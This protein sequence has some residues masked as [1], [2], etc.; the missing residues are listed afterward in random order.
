MDT[1]I[2]DR[3]GN[4][5]LE[6][7]GEIVFAQSTN[8]GKKNCTRYHELRLARTNDSNWV[9][10]IAFRGLG[11]G[12]YDYDWAKAGTAEEI[13]AWVSEFDPNCV[14]IGFPAGEKFAEKQRR[15]KLD[16]ELRFKEKASLLLAELKITEK[17]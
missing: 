9:A 4:I 11:D 15:L 17:I 12:D 1:I 6:F 14:L 16:I 2:F 13:A 3:S 7:I 5:P 10:A 8:T